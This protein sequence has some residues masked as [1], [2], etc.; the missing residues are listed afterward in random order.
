MQFGYWN[1]SFPTLLYRSNVAYLLIYLI[2]SL[3]V[4]PTFLVVWMYILFL[5][6]EYICSFSE[7][8]WNIC[9]SVNRKVCF[10]KLCISYPKW[11]KKS[12]ESYLLSFAILSW[13][14]MLT[15]MNYSV[16]DSKRYILR[17][18]FHLP[19]QTMR[20]LFFLSF[21]IRP[22]NK[23]KHL[24]TRN[25]NNNLQFSKSKQN[26]SYSHSYQAMKDVRVSLLWHSSTVLRS[27]L[28]VMKPDTWVFEMF[29]T[30]KQSGSH[31]VAKDLVR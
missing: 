25:C 27:A 6:P 3:A 5:L 10:W 11:K 23:S 29:S 16:C 22:T 21:I 8:S 19:N 7:K 14:S 1:I 24:K 13:I 12:P 18:I 2:K 4:Q 17:K 20:P 30:L 15:A 26:I 9:K 31:S 28:L